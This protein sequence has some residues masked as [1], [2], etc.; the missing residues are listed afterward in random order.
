VTPWVTLPPGKNWWVS[1]RNSQ[2]PHFPGAWTSDI[3]QFKKR[4]LVTQSGDINEGI[5]L[6]KS[7]KSR[8]LPVAME[9]ISE[10][11]L[12]FLRLDN[13]VQTL[14][15]YVETRI[16]L[17][18]IEIREDIAKAIARGVV[19]LAILLIG[20]IFLIF[21]SIGLAHFLNQFFAVT[22]AGYWLVAG[23]YGLL[24]LLLILFRKDIHLYFERKLSEMIKHKGK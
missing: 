14:T 2:P 23:F 10:T 4:G 22:Y 5:F 12:K 18:K 16:A 7:V 13:F 20:F 8:I 3:T 9:K 21:F 19:T 6:T 11:I 1:S 15:G 24:F 17:L